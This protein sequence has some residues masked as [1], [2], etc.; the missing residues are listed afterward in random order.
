MKDYNY[1]VK[2][3]L[4]SVFTTVMF[5]FMLKSLSG[6]WLS[7]HISLGIAY[8]IIIVIG[9]FGMLRKR[10]WAPI[11][12]LI[13]FASQAIDGF[14]IMAVN[15]HWSV[16]FFVGICMI[17]LY[18]A[19]YGADIYRRL[20]VSRDRKVKLS[21]KNARVLKEFNK[22][23]AKFDKKGV[24]KK[25]AKKASSAKK[26][27]KKAPKKSKTVKKEVKKEAKKV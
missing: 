25:V 12:F 26:P 8:L 17:A 7:V 9:L 6:I 13:L 24:K 21:K 18:N 3:F 15:R 19:V 4:F 11:P 2:S 10:L 5:L 23:A 20:K 27:T 1:Y 14:Y 22:K 16:F